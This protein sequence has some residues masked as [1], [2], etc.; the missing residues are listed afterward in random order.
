[1]P[2]M[3]ASASLFNA[4]ARGVPIKTVSPG[5]LNN[6]GRD[7]LW[8]TGKV[9]RKAPKGLMGGAIASAVGPSSSTLWIEDFL[10]TGGL[11]IDDVYIKQ[12]PSTDVSTVLIQDAV[13]GDWIQS[14]LAAQVEPTG[15][16]FVQGVRKDAGNLHTN[17]AFGPDLLGE[18][19][20]VG[21]AVLRAMSRTID[22]HLQGTTKER[23][24]GRSRCEGPGANTGGGA[25]DAVAGVR[26][27]AQSRS[28]VAQG[29]PD[30]LAQHRW[31]HPATTTSSTRT[32]SLMPGSSTPSSASS[33]LRPSRSR[34]H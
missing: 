22:K 25:Q 29:N 20:E 11:N 5:Y 21:L 30:C 33:P 14:N 24:H 6:P 27:G 4:I 17:F 19:P 9:A 7:G 16:K 2:A 1:M 8:V 13:E 26:P 31:R 12:F 3:G 32:R 10:K 28:R 34:R 23:R 18:R 15:A